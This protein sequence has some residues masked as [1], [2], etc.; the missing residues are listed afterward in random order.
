MGDDRVDETSENYG[1]DEVGYELGAL[2]DGTDGDGGSGGSESPLEEEV[3][4]VT[5]R[6]IVESVHTAT[7][8]TILALGT[9]RSVR[10]PVPEQ[11]ER[12]GTRSTVK[13]VLDQDVHS[14]LGANSTGTE[15]RRSRTE[16]KL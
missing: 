4:P 6:G 16:V 5:H 15:L 14:V 9:A 3:R 2:S 8:E 7:D 1:E 10:K 12:D 13:D 11:V